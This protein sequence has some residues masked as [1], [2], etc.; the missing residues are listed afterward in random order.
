MVNEKPKEYEV[1]KNLEPDIW[2]RPSLVV[3]ILADEIT[4][5]PIHAAG[6]AL[7]FPRLINFRDDKDPRDST[8]LKELT[9]LFE[10]QKV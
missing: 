10:M 6:L 5:S 1:N 9:H 7:R 4:K 3:E 2:C 8:T